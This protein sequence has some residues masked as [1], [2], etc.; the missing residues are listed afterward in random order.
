V[1]PAGLLPVSSLLDGLRPLPP[2]E[3]CY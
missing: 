2:A 3:D 1:Y